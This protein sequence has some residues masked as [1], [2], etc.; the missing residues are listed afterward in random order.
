MMTKS[1][2]GVTLVW[3][4]DVH[5][6]D[7]APRS[8][9]DDWTATLLD[10]LEQVGAIAREVGADA[11]IDGGDLFHIKSPVKTSHKLVHK[12]MDVH[13]RYHVPTYANIG[14][15]DCVYGDYE[16]L[17]QQPL[18]V[19]F[20]SGTLKRL[21]DKHEAVFH[22]SGGIT[23]RVVGVPYHG[24]EYDLERFKSIEKGDE[25]YLVVV[26]HVLATPGKGGVG[27]MFGGEDI[28]G[29]DF[30]KT[31][32]ADCFMFGHWHK[33]Q[34]IT[35]ICPGKWVINT[36]SLTRG[37]LSQDE[38]TRVPCCVVVRFT[39]SGIKCER[40]PLEILPAEQVF[41]L[42]AK[43]RVEESVFVMDSFIESLQNVLDASKGKSLA[44]AIRDSDVH[45]D[46]K[47]RAILYVEQLG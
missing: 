45:Q 44:D 38:L 42:E 17:E 2:R 4:T 46:V 8:R 39:E 24:S 9:T 6:A 35:E 25:D 40:R 19:L 18:G 27:A 3:R 37:A 23:V 31:L 1:E 34:G 12:L 20:S 47:E 15:H 13:D 11:V 30:L 33:D 28:I 10:K 16:Y 29:Y 32:D 21:Y 5:I 36:G 26:G 22:T 14:N 41:D 43:A 7:K